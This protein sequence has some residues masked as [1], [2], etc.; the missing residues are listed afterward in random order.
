MRAAV[1]DREVGDRAE[2]PLEPD[3]WPRYV[4]SSSYRG[5]WG[6]F[7]RRPWRGQETSP[8]QVETSAQP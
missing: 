6:T 8:Q 7:G 5:E 4:V 2:V 3:V 1:L